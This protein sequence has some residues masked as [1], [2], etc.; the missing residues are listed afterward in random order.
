MSVQDLVYLCL[1][2]HDEFDRGHVPAEIVASKRDQLY[3]AIAAEVEPHE[4]IQRTVLVIHGRD[5]DKAELLIRFLHE[6]GLAPVRFADRPSFGRSIIEKFES[7][8]SVGCA[9][10]LLTAEE[11][12]GV[13]EAL[14]SRARQN[15]FFELGYFLG[16][17]GRNRVIVISEGQVDLPSDFLGIYHIDLDKGREWQ[18][19]LAS[20][21]ES[22]GMEVKPRWAV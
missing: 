5:M 15:L 9:V 21:L 20:E 7:L 6:V 2:H 14:H 10:V 12:G 17:L 16:R 4:D 8:E 22:L 1:E 19:R 13:P 11:M 18:F 3:Q